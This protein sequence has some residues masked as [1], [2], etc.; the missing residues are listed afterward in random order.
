M[1]SENYNL[2]IIFASSLLLLL[3]HLIR[4]FRWRMILSSSNLY[5]STRKPLLALTLG[6]NVGIFTPLFVGD[7]F[8]SFILS[9]L[10]RIDPILTLATVVYERTIDLIIITSIL[11]VIAINLQDGDGLPVRFMALIMILI[12]LVIFLQRSESLRKLIWGI[13]SIFNPKLRT[14]VLHFIWNLNNIFHNRTINKNSRFWFLTFAM[15]VSYLTSLWLFCFGIN[16]DYKLIFT[17]IYGEPGLQSFLT[18]ISKATSVGILPLAIYLVLPPVLVTLLVSL[19]A[20]PKWRINHKLSKLSEFP[21]LVINSVKRNYPSFSYEKDY[22]DF[23]ESKFS[24]DKSIKSVFTGEGLEGVTV[25][26]IFPGGSTAITALIELDFE[27][28][29]RKFAPH[30]VVN[31]LEKQVDWLDKYKKDLPVAEL[32]SNLN[33][34]S[35]GIYYDMKFNKSAREFYDVIQ[36]E[37]LEFSK[38]ILNSVFE[39]ISEFHKKTQISDFDENKLNQYF[40]V[41]VKKNLDQ[42]KNNQNWLFNSEEFLVNGRLWNSTYL[43]FL[44]DFSQFKSLIVSKSQSATHGDLTIENMLV[45]MSV[46]N[47]TLG[48]YLIDPNPSSEFS[49]PLNDFS[50]L[51]QSLNLGYETLNRQ[52]ELIK[53]EMNLEI[54]IRAIPEYEVLKNELTSYISNRFSEEVLRE[55]YLHE[56]IDYLRLIPYQFRKSD[57]RGLAFTACFAILVIEFNEKFINSN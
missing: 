52:P 7:L 14:A 29:V 36:T 9:A 50:K 47:K 18:V 16:V 8:R 55:V 48:W 2:A 22:V 21:D 34:D 38:K 24:G 15:W 10:E 17:A 20:K 19:R 37:N 39:T 23:L 56:I 11:V 13:I 54:A 57:Y 3:G 45:D 35:K 25:L 1:K 40:Q 44:E 42:L 41:K 51:M 49:S 53:N 43:S 5:V 32:S 4:T 30:G 12:V 6:Y 27:S 26:K 46:K 33:S 31:N 28:V